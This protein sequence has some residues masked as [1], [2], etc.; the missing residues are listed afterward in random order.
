MVLD[1]PLQCVA[2]L[3]GDVS[4]QSFAEP[5]DYDAETAPEGWHGEMENRNQ[6]MIATARYMDPSNSEW[7]ESTF[8]DN[9]YSVIIMIL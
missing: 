2:T 1:G 7:E 8:H 3:P 5:N 4:V 9:V 6:L